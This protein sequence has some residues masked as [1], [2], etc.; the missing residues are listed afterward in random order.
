VSSN[1]SKS[2]STNIVRETPKIKEAFP[3]LQN[4]KIE[5]VQ[6]IISRITKPKPHISMTTKQ[7]SCKQ[8]IIP[9]SIDNT[10]NFVK[11]SNIHVTNINRAFKNIKSD[12]MA[13][14]IWVENNGIII[15]TN[16]DTNPLDLQTIENY[17][18]SACS[19][20]ADQMESPRLP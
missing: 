9:M 1:C 16:K 18:K 11:E 14:F 7:P 10:N 6:K 5:Q 4:K 20:E 17:V 13:D 15:S 12:I 8:V 19:I 2:N 3:S